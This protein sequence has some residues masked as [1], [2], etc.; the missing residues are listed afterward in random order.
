MKLTFLQGEGDY[1]YDNWANH[2]A[3]WKTKEEWNKKV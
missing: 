2:I 1:K 3:C